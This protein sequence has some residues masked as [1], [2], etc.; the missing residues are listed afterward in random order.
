MSSKRKNFIKS[1][2]RMGSLFHSFLRVAR[3]K[4]DKNNEYTFI[5]L[6][7]TQY[8]ISI[9]TKRNLQAVG[10]ADIEKIF[11]LVQLDFYLR[12]PFAQRLR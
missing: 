7:G 3:I 9:F 4:P 11:V 1:P 2:C 6:L 10:D 8:F 5:F 12:T